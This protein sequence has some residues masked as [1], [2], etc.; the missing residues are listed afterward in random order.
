MKNMLTLDIFKSLYVRNAFN[1]FLNTFINLGKTFSSTP[2]HRSIASG[3]KWVKW[4]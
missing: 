1:L 2:H 4:V 3:V